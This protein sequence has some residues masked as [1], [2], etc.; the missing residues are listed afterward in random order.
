M[1]TSNHRIITSVIDK[2]KSIDRARPILS[3]LDVGIGFGKY[4]F[5]VR[6][7]LDIRMNRYDKKDWVVEIDGV[8][9]FKDYITPVH[10]YIYDAI[11]TGSIVDIMSTLHNYDLVMLFDILEHLPKKRGREVIKTLYSKTNTLFICS[12]PDTLKDDANIEWKNPA[13]RHQCL[14]TKSEVELLIGEMYTLGINTYSKVK[15]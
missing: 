4:G 11:Y 3:V 7:L 1:P 5:L 8:E 10:D 12:F 6:E 9:I 2:I 15:K 14:W 13:E